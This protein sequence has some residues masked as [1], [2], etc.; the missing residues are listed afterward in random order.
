MVEIPKYWRAHFRDAGTGHLYTLSFRADNREDA[1]AHAQ[2]CAWS[3]ARTVDHVAYLGRRKSI[4][5]F[6]APDFGTFVRK[7]PADLAMCQ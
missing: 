6:S 4:A 2:H 5:D 1:T 7:L 3:E